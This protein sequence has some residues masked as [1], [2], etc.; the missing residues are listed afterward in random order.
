MN[1]QTLDK[2][3]ATFAWAKPVVL[4]RWLMAATTTA[5]FPLSCAHAAGW[6]HRTGQGYT[7][8]DALHKRLNKYNYP[9]PLKQPNNCGW[10]A[11]LS[12]PGFTEP[13]WQELD[14][15]QN[16]ALVYKL[17]KYTWSSGKPDAVLPK[18]ELF[19]RQDVEQ[20]IEQGGRIQLWRTHLISNFFNKNHPERWTPPGLQN[21][22]QLRYTFSSTS[23]SEQT[24]ACSDIP[25]AGWSGSLFILNDD[26]TDIHPEIGLAGNELVNRTLVL[27]KSK[28]HFL[29]WSGGL[30][31][32]LGWDIGGGPNEFCSLDYT[33]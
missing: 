13:P 7:L 27:Y 22:V 17:I 24:N 2:I 8:C 20:F 1:N 3:N 25:W 6:I 11:A 9:D 12:Y 31:V 16:R 26:L 28:P 19:V 5:A 4:L 10:N 14:P 21:V 33:H 32:S 18:Q 23:K 15:A 30:S 29:S